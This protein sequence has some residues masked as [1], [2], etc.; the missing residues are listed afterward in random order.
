MYSCL[1]SCRKDPLSACI[2]KWKTTWHCRFSS[3]PSMPILCRFKVSQLPVDVVLEHME[4]TS[5]EH[6]PSDS[7]FRHGSNPRCHPYWLP[8][9]WNPDIKLADCLQPTIA[10]CYFAWHY[11][12]QTNSYK[13]YILSKSIKYFLAGNHRPLMATLSHS[14]STFRR[15]SARNRFPFDPASFSSAFG[16]SP[17][18]PLATSSTK[19]S[20]LSMSTWNHGAP[21]WHGSEHSPTLVSY[22]HKV[23]GPCHDGK[24]NSLST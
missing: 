11:K 19:S 5:K 15:R 3:T 23:T 12:W 18:S 22:E 16:R 21:A 8:P 2:V 20:K 6:L 13:Y 17:W 1:L 24:W 10:L 4:H 7:K 14:I 9:R